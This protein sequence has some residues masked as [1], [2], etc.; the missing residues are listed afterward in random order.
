MKPITLVSLLGL[1]TFGAACSG[2]NKEVKQTQEKT[3]AVKQDNT[4]ASQPTSQPAY[5]PSEKVIE[6]RVKAAKLLL[7]QTDA[8]K[9]VWKAMEAQGGLQK[10]YA[11][12]PIGFRFN[13]QPVSG[14]RQRDS[15]QVID[16]W[17]SKARHQ[18]SANKEIEF[19]WDGER[20]WKKVP[21]GQTLPI[22]PR[23]WALTPYYF[24]AMPFV[25]ADPGV[26]L[27]KLSSDTTIDGNVYKSVKVT[28]GEDVGDS[29]NDYYII[30]L[31]PQT[32]RLR[33]LTYIVTYK[34]FFPNGGQSPEKL[35]H[36]GGDQTINGIA[37]PTLF[38][39]YALKDGKKDK[40]VTNTTLSDVSF[41]PKTNPSYF[42]MPKGAVEVKSLK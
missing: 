39:T 34:G 14:S 2:Q 25:L 12:G 5:P 9:L 35:M 26:K 17:S 21:A 13:Y 20:A 16:T 28:F 29:P 19:G 4:P 1:I 37:L 10:W 23:F 22:N 6:S 8:G 24:V 18:L 33:Y 3:Q 15:Y 30:H 36:Y 41:K 42:E 11:Q 32:G 31:E 40:L 38:K 7:N 27:K